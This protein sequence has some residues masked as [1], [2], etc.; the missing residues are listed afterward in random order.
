VLVAVFSPQL[1][2]LL[3]DRVLDHSGGAGLD[4]LPPHLRKGSDTVP[5][6]ASCEAE[7]PRRPR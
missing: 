3:G 1:L 7:A 4:L 5:V 6:V 2:G